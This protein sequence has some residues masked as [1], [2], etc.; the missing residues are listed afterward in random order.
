MAP[1]MTLFIPEGQP[2][3]PR[4][5]WAPRLLCWAPVLPAAADVVPALVEEARAVL[6]SLSCDV[7]L[8]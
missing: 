8:K 1:S 3:S 6:A 4:S 7:R 5:R 2:R